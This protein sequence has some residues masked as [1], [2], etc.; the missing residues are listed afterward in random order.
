LTIEKK[1]DIAPHPGKKIG[2]YGGGK[3]KEKKHQATSGMAPRFREKELPLRE[4]VKSW[5]RGEGGA[6]KARATT[7]TSAKGIRTPTKR[8]KKSQQK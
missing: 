1:N 3:K 5:D 7:I 8:E 2:L 6:A 4:I